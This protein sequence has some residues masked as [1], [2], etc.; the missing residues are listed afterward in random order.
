MFNER[1]DEDELRKSRKAAFAVGMVVLGLFGVMLHLNAGE[2][3]EAEAD[4]EAEEFRLVAAALKT[5][6]HAGGTAQFKR[7]AFG[8]WVAWNRN[9]DRAFKLDDHFTSAES[10]LLKLALENHATDGR[11]SLWSLCS[12]AGDYWLEDVRRALAAEAS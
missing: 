3:A 10:A 1:T 8:G 7:T 5:G 12:R 11:I 6:C 4:G 9:E 2:R